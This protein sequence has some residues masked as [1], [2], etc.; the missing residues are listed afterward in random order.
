MYVAPITA[1]RLRKEVETAQLFISPFR[2][3]CYICMDFGLLMP[4]VYIAGC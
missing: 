3:F 2:T 4:E 1:F